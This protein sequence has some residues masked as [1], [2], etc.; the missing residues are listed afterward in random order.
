MFNLF[1]KKHD[2]R[3]PKSGRCKCGHRWSYHYIDSNN[4]ECYAHKI[5]GGNVCVCRGYKE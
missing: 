5:D 4:N 3:N 2:I 1:K